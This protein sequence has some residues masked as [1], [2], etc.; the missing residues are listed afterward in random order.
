MTEEI[1]NPKALILP[2]VSTAIKNTLVADIGTLVFDSD[3]SKVSICKT[4]T[5]GASSWEA[6][7]SVEES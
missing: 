1:L 6:I 7:T 5:A 3:L 2:I 4:K